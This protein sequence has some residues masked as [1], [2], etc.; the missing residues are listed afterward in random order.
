MENF[1]EQFQTKDYTRKEGL[2]NNI[3]Y[4][5]L[6][7]IAANFIFLGPI[8][9]A[10]TLGIYFAWTLLYV[11][12]QIV[13]Y[14]YELTVDELVVTKIMN[15]RKRKVLATVNISEVIEV[16]SIEESRRNN[17][18][19]IK[20]CLDGVNIKDQVLYIKTSEGVVGLHVALNDNLLNVCRRLN[21]MVFRQ[22]YSRV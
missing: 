6:F 19:I 2:L 20:A 8:L 9:A 1:Y 12:N 15:K 11:R 10:L 16:K 5:I 13:E 17:K 22:M 3:S 14:E 21:P 7:L 18:K 4:A